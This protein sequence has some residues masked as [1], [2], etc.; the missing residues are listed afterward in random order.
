MESWRDQLH[1]TPNCDIF[2]AGHLNIATSTNAMSKKNYCVRCAFRIVIKS[3]LFDTIMIIAR[4]CLWVWTVYLCLQ[5][6]LGSHTQLQTAL[7]TKPQT[8]KFTGRGFIYW[9][10]SYTLEVKSFFLLISNI[11]EQ[12]WRAKTNNTV[13]CFCFVLTTNAVAYL[14]FS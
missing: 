3:F 12:T 4:V 2:I 5:H 7:K 6:L 14:P 9:M 13:S 8:S 10:N 1:I 11:W